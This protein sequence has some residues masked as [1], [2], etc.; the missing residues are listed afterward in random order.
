M[1]APSM[2]LDQLQQIFALLHIE[3]NRR[4]FVRQVPTSL[5]MADARLQGQIP[6]GIA[7]DAI[8]PTFLIRHLARS[9]GWSEARMIAE[10][11]RQLDM[12]SNSAYLQLMEDL[13]EPAE[14]GKSM[15]ETDA[16]HL[17]PRFDSQRS[18]L[19]F[20]NANIKFQSRPGGNTAVRVLARF[21]EQHWPE[22]IEFPIADAS[23][24]AQHEVA[25]RLRKRTQRIGLDFSVDAHRSVISWRRTQT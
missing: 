19:Y 10:V 16:Q 5:E 25:R 23:P 8:K 17:A 12:V 18:V 14:S 9:R 3:R 13:G 7:D 2:A 4:R 15:R 20:R 11:G 1:I 22:E 21:E 6:P 24:E